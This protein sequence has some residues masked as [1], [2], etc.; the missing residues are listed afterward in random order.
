MGVR[1]GKACADMADRALERCRVLVVEDEYFLADDIARSL[2][3]L[4]AEVIGPIGTQADALAELE[5]SEGLHA[6]VLDVNLNGDSI[7]PVA[8]ALRARGIPFVFGTGYEGAALPEAYRD[9]PRWQKPF[10]PEDLVKALPQLI[11]PR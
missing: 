2:R 10:D 4:G 8:E 5:K 6:A 1:V 3:E 9:V 7:Y 11:R